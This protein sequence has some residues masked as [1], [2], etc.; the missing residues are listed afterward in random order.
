MEGV[1]NGVRIAYTD[2]SEDALEVRFVDGKLFIS[3]DALSLNRRTFILSEGETVFLLAYCSH[4]YETGA[5]IDRSKTMGY[6]ISTW[7]IRKVHLALPID[8]DFRQWLAKQPNRD[9]DG[10]ENVGKR[11]C[12][13]DDES[14]IWVA[15]AKRTWK[16]PLSG[17]TLSGVVESDKLLLQDIDMTGDGSNR[18]YSDILVP[19]FK[20][21]NG[22]LDA[23]IVWAHGDTVAQVRIHDGVL[24]ED[25]IE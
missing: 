10:S 4:W 3:I 18:I 19:L 11:E 13:N 20:E 24:E 16:L 15:T 21:F 23:I 5:G 1:E 17:H 8:F 2:G 12:L 7:K 25:I 6:N 22:E 9:E 14:M